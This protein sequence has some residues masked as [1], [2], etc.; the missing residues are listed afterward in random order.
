M[1]LPSLPSL[2]LDPIAFANESKTATELEART[3]E[4][5]RAHVGFDVA[6]TGLRGAAPT[7]F[8]LDP[9][10]MARAKDNHV[11]ESELLPVKVAARRA[12]GVAVDTEV[13]GA[14]RTKT[15]YFRELVAPHRGHHSLMGYFELRGEIIGG[16]MLGRTSPTPF[17]HEELAIVTR[18]LPA[19]ALARASFG[20]PGFVS[21]PLARP[22]SPVARLGRWLDRGVVARSKSELSPDLELLVRDTREHREM[23]ARSKSTDAEMVWSRAHLDEPSRSGWPYLD[24]VHLAA[25]LA[26]RRDRALFLGCGGAVAPRR[27]AELHRGAAID[28]VEPDERVVELAHAHYALGDIPNLTV[29]LDEGTRFVANA[30][31]RDARWD[32]IV[33]DAYDAGDL[34]GGMSSATFFAHLRRALARGG[35]FAFNVV[36][37]LDGLASSPLTSVLAAAR[38]YFDDVR[39]VPVVPASEQPFDAGARRNVVVV[40]RASRDA[41]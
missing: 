7:T 12:G 10:V 19:L 14:S 29:H 30:A 2:V 23:I 38:A 35:A 11:Y 41:E 28:V 27:F 4:L 6:F 26:S 8:G 16:L 33:V 15:A 25:S 37:A 5:L 22:R 21:R 20:L 17:R 34:A 13:L 18:L 40:G 3:I 36:A 31:L 1:S 9:G 24:L 39:V 32:V